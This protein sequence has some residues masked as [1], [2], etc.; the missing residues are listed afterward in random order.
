MAEWMKRETW[1]CGGYVVQ[2]GWSGLWFV[3]TYL[4]QD[5]RI[6]GPMSLKKCRDWVERKVEA[7]RGE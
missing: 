1:H 7:D 4:N 6:A 3:T 2:P 5:L